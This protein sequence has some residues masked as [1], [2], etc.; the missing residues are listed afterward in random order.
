MPLLVAVSLLSI[1]R[2][3]DL[4]AKSLDLRVALELTVAPL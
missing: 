2:L 3:T 4:S 1:E